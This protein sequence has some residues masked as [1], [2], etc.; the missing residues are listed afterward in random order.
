VHDLE[1]GLIVH[2]QLAP[3]EV[4]PLHRRLMERLSQMK[5]GLRHLAPHLD[6]MQNSE[7]YYRK[8]GSIVK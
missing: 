5:A 1:A 2:G 7:S 3:S 8:I 6:I 4:Q